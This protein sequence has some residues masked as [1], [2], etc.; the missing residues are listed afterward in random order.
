MIIASYNYDTR[1]SDHLHVLTVRP[2]LGKTVM[3]NR[4]VIAQNDILSDGF[5]VDVPEAMSGKVLNTFIN[6]QVIRS[7]F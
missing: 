3:T 4:G 1:T 6:D 7:L 5:N 2:G